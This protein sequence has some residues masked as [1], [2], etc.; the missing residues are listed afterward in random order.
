MMWEKGTYRCVWPKEYI[1][2]HIF[3][4]AIF[5]SS[6]ESQ[7][8]DFPGVLNKRLKSPQLPFQ[9]CGMI[10]LLFNGFCIES[11]RFQST[12]QPREPALQTADCV[13][14]SGRAPVTLVPEVFSRSAKRRATNGRKPLVSVVSWLF[15][16]ANRIRAG[17][18]S[19][20][21]CWLVDAFLE[22]WLAL[23][24]FVWG[25]DGMVV[26]KHKTYVV[27]LM[28]FTIVD[29]LDGILSSVLSTHF[30]GIE[31]VSTEQRRALCD[32][33]QERRVRHFAD[34]SWQVIDFSITSQYLQLTVVE[35]LYGYPRNAIFVVVY[36]LKSMV[37]QYKCV[38]W[39]HLV[40]EQAFYRACRASV[41]VVK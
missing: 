29:I 30:P 13:F 33:K 19:D 18:E 35:G 36:P 7:S 20:P 4:N 23:S 38:S 24:I 37:E 32:R 3:S 40:S 21:R 2:Q 26:V 11:I 27:L 1:L 9:R 8:L 15:G 28:V 17:T 6:N 22:I 14:I 39:Q 41:Y 12:L 25:V 34:W 16:S 31:S 5:A 10:L